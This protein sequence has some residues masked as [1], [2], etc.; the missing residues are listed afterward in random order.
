MLK[1]LK[2]KILK[3]IQGALISILLTELASYAFIY[4]NICMLCV[5]WVH[6]YC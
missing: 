6:T 4:Y 3:K 1:T 2:R 5:T